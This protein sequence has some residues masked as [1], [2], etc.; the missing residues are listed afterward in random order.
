MHIYCRHKNTWNFQ[1]FRQ[2]NQ[3]NPS[4]PVLQ[5]HVHL[6]TKSALQ[7]DPLYMEQPPVQWSFHCWLL[8][9]GIPSSALIL[10][11][12]V[13]QIPADQIP[14]AE[15]ETRIA[16][17]LFSCDV[18]FSLSSLSLSSCFSIRDYQSIDTSIFP[19]DSNV[20]DRISLPVPHKPSWLFSVLLS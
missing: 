15:A 10:T 3:C 5:K 18:V 17:T 11:S 2:S 7:S 6:I 14:E 8:L 12:P 4:L 20:P 1:R 19:I 13:Q 16:T 9:S